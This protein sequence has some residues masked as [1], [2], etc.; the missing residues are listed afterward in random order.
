M[1]V[2]A[3]VMIDFGNSETRAIVTAGGK[4]YRFNLSNKFA[5]VQAGYQVSTKYINSKSTI[6]V[7]NGTHYANGVIVDREFPRSC[8]SP[9]SKQSKVTQLPTELTLNL[10]FIRAVELLAQA[11]HV[12]V[13]HLDITFDVSALLPP[14]DHAKNEA[15]L[16][17]LIRKVSAVSA[18]TPSAFKKAFK[19]GNV[20][21]QSEGVAAFLGALYY[22]EGLLPSSLSDGA[23]LAAG[24]VLITEYA[25][26]TSLVEVESNT[27]FSNGYVLVLDIGA[28]TTDLAMFLDMELVEG[29]KDSFAVG[30]NLVQSIVSREVRKNFGYL[31]PDVQSLV[32]TGTLH[33]GNKTHDLSA[34]VTSAKKEYA[35]EAIIFIKDYINNM[36][37]DMP[38][39]KGLLAVG[40]GAVPTIKDGQVVSPA[41]GSVLI[42]YLKELAPNMELLN[43]EG[44][45]LRDLNIQGLMYIHKYG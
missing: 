3:G 39:V 40:G 27:D 18:L 29:S 36:N 41:M 17:A 7:A 2:K 30:G 20:S 6:F 1:I 24:D 5:E 26:N 45:D 21:V 38:V 13:D 10:V 23:S 43:T 16:E 28:G 8:V 15:L 34:L 31:P 33:E 14:L 32:L 4:N 22:E 44:K 35:R 11:F 9:A 37:V 25:S 12:G 19:I 42:E